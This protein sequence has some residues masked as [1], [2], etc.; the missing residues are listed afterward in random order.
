MDIGHRTHLGDEIADRWI[1]CQYVEHRP[2]ALQPRQTR[3]R[4]HA[5]A[6]RPSDVVRGADEVIYE[7]LRVTGLGSLQVIPGRVLAVLD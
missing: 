4:P 1:R 7:Y 3:T 2:I 5:A 6:G